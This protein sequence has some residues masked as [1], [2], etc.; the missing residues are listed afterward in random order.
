MELPTIVKEALAP[1]RRVVVLTGAGVSAESGIPTFRGEE[2]LWR[3]YRAEELA[4]PAAFAA[5]PQLVWEWYDWR[6]G[7]IGKAVPNGAHTAIAQ[8]EGLLPNFFLITQNVDGLHRQ[9]GSKKVI[10]IHGNI[11]EMRCTREGR[12]FEDHR[13][14]LPEIPPMCSCGALLRPNVVWFGEPLPQAELQAAWRI[15]EGCDTLLVVGTSGMV[16]PVAS[17]PLMVK[18]KGGKVVE[19]NLQQTRISLIADVSLFGK[20]SYILPCLLEV[21]KQME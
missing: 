13:T 8:M 16:E 14:P 20:A 12:T 19:V 10:E 6:R 5:E 4:T 11:W 1:E 17:F 9:A 3:Q 21:A 2:G 7:I 15:L 18:G